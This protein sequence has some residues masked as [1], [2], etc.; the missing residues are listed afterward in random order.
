LIMTE[1]MACDLEETEFISVDPVVRH[2]DP[3][4]K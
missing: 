2:S 3:F 4:A 1:K